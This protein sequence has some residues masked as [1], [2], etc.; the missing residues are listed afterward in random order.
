MLATYT[1]CTQK[2]TWKKKMIVQFP[3]AP[4]MGASSQWW[5]STPAGL[6]TSHLNMLLETQDSRGQ[7]EITSP[8]LLILRHA[9]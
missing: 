6:T 1:V 8:Y 9:P 4:S 7:G 3:H 2:P 5:K